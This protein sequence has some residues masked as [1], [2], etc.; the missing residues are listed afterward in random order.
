MSQSFGAPQW[1]FF[2]SH[3]ILSS[4]G[5]SNFG[6]FRNGVDTEALRASKQ[7]RRKST[8]EVKV[9]MVLPKATKLGLN[10]KRFHIN[11]TYQQCVE[12]RFITELVSKIIQ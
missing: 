5:Q 2:T 12:N 8:N 3:S 1:C 10:A 4:K 6:Y 11:L 9:V 7:K